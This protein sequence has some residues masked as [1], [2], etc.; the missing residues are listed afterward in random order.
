LSIPAE[1]R[2][3]AQL[4]AMDEPFS[5]TDAINRMTLQDYLIDT[6]TEERHT[7]VYVTHDIE[8]AVCLAD[9]IAI[10]RLSPGRLAAE[11]MVDLPR[12]RDRH[13]E[14]FLAMKSLVLKE[15]RQ[16]GIVPD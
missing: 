2:V 9:R 8:E 4:V 3:D 6:W 12:P 7:A 13:S 16:H 14:R 10:L 11:L 1:I 15:M 5:A